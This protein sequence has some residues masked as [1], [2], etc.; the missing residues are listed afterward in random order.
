MQTIILDDGKTIH[1][2]TTRKWKEIKVIEANLPESINGI[3]LAGKK[4]GEFRIFINDDLSEHRK[5]EAFVH[6]M[7]HL[8][9][10][11]LETT[12]DG[13]R[14]TFLN[15]LDKI[16]IDCHQATDEIMKNLDL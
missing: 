8:Y 13:D 4:T 9:R 6:E 7:I 14:K 12:Y 10:G 1:L 16:E 5:L 3:L 11:D 15:R 2:N